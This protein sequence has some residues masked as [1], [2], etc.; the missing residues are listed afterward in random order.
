MNIS[1]PNSKVILENIS[2]HIPG[3]A[4]VV[5]L[6]ESGS[7]KST[8]S[9]VLKGLIRPSSGKV[10]IDGLDPTQEKERRDIISRVGL[11]FSNPSRQLVT[12][13]V[14]DDV[15]FGLENQGINHEV[16]VRRVDEILTLLDIFRLK[17]E[18]TYN[19]SMG[20]GLLVAAAGVLVMNPK[21]LILDEPRAFVG[22]REFNVLFSAI[23]NLQKSKKQTLVWITHNPED[24][25]W[26]DI[27]LV[28][29]KGKTCYYGKPLDFFLEEVK[30][31][32]ESFFLPDLFCIAERFRKKGLLGGMSPVS[33]DEFVERL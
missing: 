13:K 5:I 10:L 18:M 8:L 19:L 12:P 11:L 25:L 16:A 1:A 17:K 33:L 23:M 22:C 32:K 20:E 24:A 21:A 3:G 29:S 9:K 26:A 15:M 2:F 4:K 28:L 7:G 30:K 31:E 27:L 14:M 6:G